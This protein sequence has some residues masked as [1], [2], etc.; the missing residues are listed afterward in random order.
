M[1]TTH[2]L[3]LA[4]TRGVGGVT[5]RK[6]LER[7][8]N[9]ESIFNASPEELAQVPRVT[10][11]IAQ[12][13][14]ATPL[15]QLDAELLSLGDE[16]IQVLTWEDE[17]YPMRLRNLHNAPFILFL[18]GAL[19][20]ADDLSVAIVGTRH[21]SSQSITLAETIA[22]ELAE[23]GLTI[24]SGLAEG[25][26]TAS[27]RGALASRRGRTLAVL[28]SGIRVIH[29][30]ANVD[31][32]IRV[33][34][35]GALLSEFHPNAPPRGPQLMARDRII[36]GLSRAVIVVEAGAK[37][38]SM[39]TASRAQKQ[40]RRVYAI[41]GSLGTDKLLV[42][43]AFPLIPENV[44]FDQLADELSQ[45]SQVEPPSEPKQGRLF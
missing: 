28:G 6:M 35:R 3:A 18:R 43:N 8:G 22:K 41:P 31:L 40:G 2:W 21:P 10:P 27:H 19:L 42:E 7:F 16:G 15:E 33:A 45:L 4:F 30:R 44:D 5:V 20:A 12:Q 39:D 24:V 13:L 36:S 17:A 29:P 1:T 14:L 32:S 23:R 37:S 34:Q 25:I 11:E 9:V 26:D 38:G